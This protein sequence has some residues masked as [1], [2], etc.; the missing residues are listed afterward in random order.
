M[1]QY[2][3][4]E[5]FDGAVPAS[6]YKLPPRKFKSMLLNMGEM[7]AE[8]NKVNMDFKSRMSI[9]NIYKIPSQK[10]DDQE[11]VDMDLAIPA[12]VC[13]LFAVVP[14]LLEGSSSSSVSLLAYLNYC[15]N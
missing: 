7:L 3:R 10:C 8:S 9:I 15:E 1:Y 6:R 14:L 12:T 2:H 5:R 13:F 4:D 11:R